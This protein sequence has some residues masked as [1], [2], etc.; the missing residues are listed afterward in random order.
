M[1]IS[2]KQ[3]CPKNVE[4]A[5]EP[6]LSSSISLSNQRLLVHQM[7]TQCVCNAPD[8]EIDNFTAKKL[9]PFY[10]ALLETLEN[11]EQLN[12]KHPD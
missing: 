12:I 8:D 5:I 2:L 9:T 7:F 3:N 10:L 1:P 11:L 6:L 4:E